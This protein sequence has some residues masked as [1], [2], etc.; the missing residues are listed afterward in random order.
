MSSS[1]LSNSKICQ[2][3]MYRLILVSTYC[4]CSALTGWLLRR[5]IH[6]LDADGHRHRENSVRV[7]ILKKNVFIEDV[8]EV[9]SLLPDVEIWGVQRS[10]F[11]AIA[12][13]FLPA[14]IDD[15]SYISEDVS[16]EKSKLAYREYLGK[17][18]SA[19]NKGSR[20]SAVLSGNFGYYA[21]RELA[22]AVNSLSVPFI[23]LHKENLKTPGR[24]A[25][26]GKIYRE[27]RGKY[28]GSQILVYNQVE[29]ELIVNSNV[30]ELSQV[31]IVGMPRLD[32]IHEWR[33]CSAGCQRSKVIL[34]FGFM[35]GNR[36]PTII[37][38]KSNREGT[39]KYGRSGGVKRE[40][41]DLSGLCS[42]VHLVM[43]EIAREHPD[44]VVV[45]KTKGRAC[46]KRSL[47]KQFN[48]T[49]VEELPDNIVVEHGGDPFQWL[50]KAAVTCGVNTTALLEA[51]AAGISVVQPF[52]GESLEPETAPFILDLGKAAYRADSAVALKEKL[53]EKALAPESIPLDLH[54]DACQMLSYWVG[55]PDGLACQRAAN[56]IRRN[57][58]V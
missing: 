55:N 17:V 22:A 27:K 21:E 48:V 3:W 46:D 2:R 35:P 24:A 39:T 50:S 30:A 58:R 31:H 49:S 4:R 16:I 1:I 14:E 54:E 45:V 19:F 10:F 6:C 32:K 40:R 43:L 26:W 29:R 57:L 5:S 36:L 12:S 20:F 53:V 11:K 34:F 44:V 47:L 8:K 13:V 18:W 25:V 38:N 9:M 51:L 15:N 7:L 42:Q 56:L 41:I 52:F 33:K 37:N 28:L 23:V